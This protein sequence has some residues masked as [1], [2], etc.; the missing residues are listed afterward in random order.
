LSRRSGQM[1][2]NIKAAQSV[3]DLN[4]STASESNAGLNESF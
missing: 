4:Q 3:M 2:L 1:P